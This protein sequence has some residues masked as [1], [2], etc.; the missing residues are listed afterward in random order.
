MPRNNMST[1]ATNAPTTH[2]LT[3][4]FL[5][6]AGG[7]TQ[8]ECLDFQQSLLDR[9]QEGDF[10]YYTVNKILCRRDIHS[11]EPQTRTIEVLISDY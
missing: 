9:V 6:W 2:S 10:V 7:K 1:Q 3:K 5:K 4:P 8:F 11:K